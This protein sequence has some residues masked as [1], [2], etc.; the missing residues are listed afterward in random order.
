VHYKEC[1]DAWITHGVIIARTHLRSEYALCRSALEAAALTLRETTP[2]TKA[3]I[4][5]ERVFKAF[6][7]NI[8]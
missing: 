8:A 5:G 4:M 2:D 6:L 7:A 1:G 3:L